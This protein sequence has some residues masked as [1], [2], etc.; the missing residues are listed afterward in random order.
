VSSPNRIAL[1]T[2]EDVD[3]RVARQL[4]RLGYD[5][6]SSH[7][8]GNSGHGLSDDWQL[9]YAARNQRVILSHNVSDFYR[10]AREWHIGGREH[11][12][13]VVASQLELGALIL[14]CAQHIDRVSVEDH[15]NVLMYLG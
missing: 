14:R 9:E 10:L 13:I 11:H 15:Y 1:Y 8:A 4:Q 5:V 6:V 2:D 12:G 3:G 7:A